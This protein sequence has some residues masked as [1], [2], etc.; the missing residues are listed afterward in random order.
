VR[1]VLIWVVGLGILFG[2][3]NV[4]VHAKKIDFDEWSFL[5]IKSAGR[6]GCYL[7]FYSDKDT[8][9][10]NPALLHYYSSHL[11]FG[12]SALLEGNDDLSDG[13]DLINDLEDIYDAYRGSVLLSEKIRERLD[14]ALQDKLS[15]YIS[16]GANGAIFTKKMLALG[17]MGQFI[18]S[19]GLTGTSVD[20]HL[21]I[22]AYSSK[23]F[24]VSVP[25]KRRVFNKR[26]KV[27]ITLKKVEA[28]SVSLDWNANTVA[29]NS[30]DLLDSIDDEIKEDSS[31]MADIGIAYKNRAG[32][33]MA[34]VL[35]N[36]GKVE[37]A[38]G[39]EI[40]TTLDIGIRKKVGLFTLGVEIHDIGTNS[41]FSDKLKIGVETSKIPFV[42]VLRAGYN[43]SGATFGLST[44]LFI[45]N[46]DFAVYKR[47][48]FEDT[49]VVYSASLSL[50]F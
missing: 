24:Y 30:D 41:D 47:K 5:N 43:N 9:Y 28:G 11:D 50:R 34:A 2:W 38:G 49:D 14:Q 6:G 25:L 22:N 29:N 27:G 12:A 4:V 32:I 16:F 7:T 45:F 1:R 36:I 18:V 46:F 17:G 33:F 13:W 42:G 19:L 39:K 31:V 40:G 26:F 35:R 48:M 20:P 8:A 10:Y 37:M 44:R 15:P 23:V 3:F 21:K